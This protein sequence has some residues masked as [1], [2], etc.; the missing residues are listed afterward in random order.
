MRAC[1]QRVSHAQVFV[2]GEV[3]GEI[4]LG[5]LVLLGVASD[6]EIDD[7]RWLADK[8]VELRVF[9]DDEGKMNRSVLEAG[10]AVLAVS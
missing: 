2:A 5:L 4:G 10:G 7:A 1:V 6:D 9:P 8:T 3:V